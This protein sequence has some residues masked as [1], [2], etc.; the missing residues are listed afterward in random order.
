MLCESRYVELPS[1]VL[2]YRHPTEDS[3]SN[4]CPGNNALRLKLLALPLPAFGVAL[5]RRERAVAVVKLAAF[6]IV[7]RLAC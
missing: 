3:L 6:R 7:R 4:P 2:A 5:P 1:R